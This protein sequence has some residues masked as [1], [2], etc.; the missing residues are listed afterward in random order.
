MRFSSILIGFAFFSAFFI[1]LLSL[2]QPSRQLIIANGGDFADT[3]DAATVAAWNLVT[4][5]YFIFDTIEVSS[6]QDVLV[7]GQYAYVA[8][9]GMI[10]KYNIDTYTR[11]SSVPAPG[12]RS[13]TTAPNQAALVAACGFPVNSDYVRI[14]NQSDLSEVAAVQN[15][16]GQCEGVVVVND[17][18]YVTV[19]GGFGSTTGKVA[20]INLNNSTLITEINLDSLGESVTD[21]FFRPGDSMLYTL[22][23]LSFGST[24]GVISQIPL[25]ARTAISTTVPYPIGFNG[26]T[27]LVGN[28]L[29][30]MFDGAFNSVE[31]EG[32]NPYALSNTP[33]IPGPWAGSAMDTQNIEFYLSATDY[34]TWGSIY[35]YN[36]SGILI[37]SVAVGVSP[38]AFDVD[39]RLATGS[40]DLFSDEVIVKSYPN[41]FTDQV[42]IDAS[43]LNDLPLS[44]RIYSFSGN[45][46]FFTSE[47]KVITELDLSN[48]SAGNYLLKLHAESGDY[49]K[50]LIK[51]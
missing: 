21:I 6:V 34:S 30:G 27:T 19:P 47:V 49:T 33:M 7:D 31:I 37:D 17:T 9:D 13:I 23:S 2:A 11:M 50:H 25:G 41:P 48:L 46:V 4:G 40:S 44:I 35:R 20:L 3:T 36:S 45:C 16:S 8:A 29:Y 39:G 32:S 12:V 26:A 10:L 24:T 5:S 42:T 15:I 28:T 14:F 18:A 43:R 22:S 38:E 1:P 51:R